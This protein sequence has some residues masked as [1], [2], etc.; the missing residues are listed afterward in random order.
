MKILTK[1]LN[2]IRKP[3]TSG[4]VEVHIS[5]DTYMSEAAYVEAFKRL[6]QELRKHR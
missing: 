6:N 4:P 3:H 1:I 5:I 2:K